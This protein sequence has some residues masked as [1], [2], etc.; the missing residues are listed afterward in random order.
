MSDT[1]TLDAIR[2]VADRMCGHTLP[3]V[4]LDGRPHYLVVMSPEQL[5]SWKKMNARADWYDYYHS[6]RLLRR[7]RRNDVRRCEMFNKVFA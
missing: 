5:D 4:Y 2:A 3:P 6:M 7:I 1:L